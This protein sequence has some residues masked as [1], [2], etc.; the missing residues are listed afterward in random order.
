[1]SVVSILQVGEEQVI[2][3]VR[4]AVELAG[5]FDIPHG[6]TVLLKPNVVHPSPSGSGSITDTRV[7]EA[8]ARLVLE[9]NP[10]RVIVGEGSSVGYDFPG[11]RD[12]MTCLEASGTEAVV[13]RLGLELVDL[14][15]DE[16][17]QVHAQEAYVMPDFAVARTAWEQT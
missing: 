1:M 16:P 9:R 8:V 5:G 2:Q 14:N 4:Q 7:T 3:A 15:R 10:G 6:A 17:V 11:R 13:R 12:T